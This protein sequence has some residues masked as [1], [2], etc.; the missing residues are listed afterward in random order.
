MTYDEIDLTGLASTR[1]R[2]RLEWYDMPVGTSF[3]CDKTLANA[4]Q[5]ASKANKANPGKRFIA[6]LVGDVVRIGRVE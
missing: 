5:M 2:Q 3:V 4:R 6:R 1:T